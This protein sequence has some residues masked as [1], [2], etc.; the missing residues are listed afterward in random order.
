MIRI[1]LGDI[2][3]SEMK[4]L[5]NTINCVGVMGKG[6]AKIYK[7]RYPKMFEEYKDMCTKS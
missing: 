4:T 6:I 7:D 3:E 1:K 2:F 5:V